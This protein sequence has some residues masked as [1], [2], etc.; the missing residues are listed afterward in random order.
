MKVKQLIIEKLYGLYNY[1][2]NFFEDVTFLYGE[3][4]CGK[5]TVLDILGAIVTGKLYRLFDY[6]FNRITLVYG[7]K[8]GEDN[9]IIISNHNSELIVQYHSNREGTM[10]IARVGGKG[11]VG[12]T[13]LLQAFPSF[14]PFQNHSTCVIGCF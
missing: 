11:F 2:I 5:T 7:V 14:N 10:R 4:G 3:N 6:D 12:L 9:F 13:F 8:N 1:N